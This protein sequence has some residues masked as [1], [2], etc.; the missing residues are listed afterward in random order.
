MEIFLLSIVQVNSTD[1]SG[2]YAVYRTQRDTVY[3]QGRGNV[4]LEQCFSNWDPRRGVRGSEIEN[5]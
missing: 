3:Q 2:I 5:A 4:G 1:V